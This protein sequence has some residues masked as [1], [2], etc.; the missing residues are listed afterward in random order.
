MTSPTTDSV[1]PYAARLSRRRIILTTAA[2]ISGMF[3]AA[4]DGTVVS[5]AMPTIIG[6]LHG[7]DDYAWVFSAYLLAEIATIPLWGKFADMYGRKKIF[8]AGMFIFLAGS[9]LCGQAHTMTE[10]IL[11]RAVQGLGAGCLLPVAQTISADLFTLEQ[12]VKVQAVFAAVFGFASIIGPLI[13]GFLTDSLSW[14]WVFY[15]NLPVGIAAAILVKVVMVEPLEHRRKHRI[16]WVGIVTL[17]GWTCLLVFALETGGRDYAWSSPVI[18]GALFGSAA[19]LVA[20]IVNERRARE[21]V[22]PL[23]L[24]RIPTLRAAAVLTVLVGMTMFAVLSFLPLFVQVVIGTD[25]TERGPCPHA[26][27]ARVHG[28]VGDRRPVAAPDRLPRPDHARVHHRHAGRVPPHPPRR[29]LDDVRDRP[30]PRVR[31][32]RRSG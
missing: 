29:R 32:A 1:T 14:R 24:F 17:L 25:A 26:D 4:L 8:L 16:D 3:L 27:D 6:D 9:V 2:V 31:R 30:R 28:L 15:V 21:P 7:I 18:V 19:L 5:T 13:G 20:F 11:F 10:L 23:D 12:R 22:V